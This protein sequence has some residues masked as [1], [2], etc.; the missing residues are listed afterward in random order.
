MRILDLSKNDIGDEGVDFLVKGIKSQPET[1]IEH[2]KLQETN[3][4]EKGC[5]ELATLIKQNKTIVKLEIEGNIVNHRY[6]QEINS[7]CLS[8]KDLKK[9]TKVPEYQEELLKLL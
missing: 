5:H 1:Q 3:L 7:F 9:K 6:M 8:N 2:L 4:G